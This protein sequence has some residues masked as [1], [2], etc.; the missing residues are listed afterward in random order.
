MSRGISQVLHSHRPLAIAILAAALV[1]GGYFR[2]HLLGAAELAPDEAAVWAAASAGNLHDVIALQRELDPGKLA[3]FDVWVH[4]W[5]K[6]LGDGVASLRA[7]G[8]ALGT[9]AIL[10]AFLTTREL[11]SEFSAADRELADLA[12]AMTALIFAVNPLMVSVGA[13]I[14]RM[15]PLVLAAELAHLYFFI[16]AQ[17]RGGVLNCVMAAMFAA[18]AVAANFTATFLFLA[19]GLWLL[20]VLLARRAGA[21]LFELR[22]GLPLVALA[23]AA[24]MIGVPVAGGLLTGVRSL[25]WGFLNWRRAEPPWWPITALADT[26][27][28]TLIFLVLAAV[29]CVG[30]LRQGRTLAYPLGFLAAWLCGPIAIAMLV[31]YTVTPMMTPSYVLASFVAFFA[32]AGIGIASLRHDWARF[33]IAALIVIVSARN[34]MR[35]RA[36]G[37]DF[38]WREA[39]ALALSAAAPGEHIGVVP[40]YAYNVV[41]Y[42]LPPHKRDVPVGLW[43]R[44]GSQRLLILARMP[45]SPVAM[46]DA[47]YPRVLER[48]RGIEIRTR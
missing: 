24:A 10:L 12:A 21:A 35:D 16:R 40:A 26:A 34:L 20:Y 18:L 7:S 13:R 1:S 38:Q 11:L 44:C 48:V 15:Y 39:S 37:D 25:Q 28:G 36:A 31:S 5:I 6:L 14:L 46:M 45:I 47:C 41:R 33:L 32:M 9:L 43:R 22:V 17:R 8:A 2:F 29:I 42:Y 4:G 30:V 27:G 19:E 3:A 23:A